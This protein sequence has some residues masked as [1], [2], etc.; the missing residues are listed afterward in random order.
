MTED[1]ALG[2]VYYRFRDRPMESAYLVAR[3][4]VEP[5]AVTGALRTL[6]RQADPDLPLTDARTMRQRLSDSL[7]LRRSPALLS[8]VFAG[9]ALLLT[10]IGTYGVVSYAVAQ[11]RREIGLRMA[12]GARREQVRRQFVGTALRLGALGT[13]LGVVGAAAAGRALQAILYQVPVL[14][15]ATLAGTAGVMLAVSLAA[16]LIPSSRAARMAPT[17]ALS[18]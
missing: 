7:L 11:R 9:F 16:C 10:A 18:E 3:T 17:V 15:V 14:P 12:L 8:A 1:E 5:A 2:A 6:V 4:S 13:A